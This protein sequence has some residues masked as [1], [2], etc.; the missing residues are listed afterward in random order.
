M[1]QRLLAL[2][3]AAGCI[4]LGGTGVLMYMGQ[5]RRPPEISV[6]KMDLSYEEGSSYSELLKGM[7]AKDNRDGDLT[8]EIFVDRIMPLGDGKATVYYGVM[9]RHKNVGTAS[10]RVTYMPKES[11]N[12]GEESAS[13][14]EDNQ[15]DNTE[16][17]KE[18]DRVSQ[19]DDQT[20][21]AGELKPDGVRPAIALNAEETKI[22]AGEAFDAL[23][24][25]EAVADDKDDQNTLYRHVHVDGQYDVNTKG[26]YELRYY[27]SDSEGN[28]SDVK[29][30]SLTVQ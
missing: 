11:S 2:A 4:V 14:Q 17:E 19:E 18:D 6:E 13:K 9:D 10:R 1:K 25:V 20:S 7:S 5:D 22:N 16:S 12:I 26:T 29:T 15:G 24:F 21:D 8:E 3:L 23:S 27:V 30:F 28:T